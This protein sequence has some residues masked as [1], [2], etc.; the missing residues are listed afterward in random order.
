MDYQAYFSQTLNNIRGEGRYRYFAPLEKLQGQY[1]KALWHTEDGIKEITIWCSN[2]YLAMGQNADVITA[3]KAALD[4]QGAGAGGTRNIGGTNNLHVQLE[5]RLAKLHNQQAALTYS[6]GWIS[7]MAGLSALGQIMPGLIYIS[8]AA[9]HNSMIA[10]IR[11]GQ[12]DKVIF[13]HNDMADLRRVL[14]SL[15]VDRPKIIVFESVYSMDGSVAPMHEICDLADEFKAMTWLDEVHAVGLYGPHGGGKSDEFGLSKRITF[16]EGTMAKALGNVGGYVTGSV[17]AVDVLRSF[18]HGFIFSTAL[19]PAIAAGAI[20]A[21]DIIMSD[22]GQALRNTHQAQA[23]KTR[24]RLLEEGFP[25]LRTTTHI[26]PLMVGDPVKCKQITDML[27]NEYGIYVQPINYPTV[28]KGTERLR[29]TPS[30]L[31][32]DAEIEHLISCLNDLRR[33][34]GGWPMKQQAA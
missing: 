25:I 4:S 22:E 28:P 32:S 5:Q 7:N 20:Q 11:A 21:I 1:P 2:D 14:E 19:P 34:I 23:E 29:L 15:P 12:T 13:K 33:K 8:D 24:Q 9:N 30:P 18:G 3:A 16:I 6:S 31:H 10:G 26:V 27:I 17:D